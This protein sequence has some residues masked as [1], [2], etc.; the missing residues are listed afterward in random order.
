MAGAAQHI[1][2]Q[3]SPERRRFMIALRVDFDGRSRAHCDLRKIT[4]TGR[5]EA[6][7]YQVDVNF[8]E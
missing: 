3:G 1:A 8:G 2:N 7:G 4:H 5:Y 6:D